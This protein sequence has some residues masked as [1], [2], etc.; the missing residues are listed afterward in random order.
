MKA[1]LVDLVLLGACEAVVRTLAP[2]LPVPERYQVVLHVFVVGLL[3]LGVAALRSPTPRRVLWGLSHLHPWRELLIGIAFTVVLYLVATAALAPLA[4]LSAKHVEAAAES[5]KAA[6]QTL[7]QVPMAPAILV[8]IF[9]GV[10]EE[11]VFRG[12]LLSR[13]QSALLR[14]GSAVA[15]RIAIVASAIVFA[16][17]HAY[18]GPVGMVQSLVV[19]VLLGFLRLRRGT[20]FAPIGSHVFIDVLGFALLPLLGAQRS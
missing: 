9:A 20:L 19:G 13:I 3:M 16:L 15:G 4:L 8:A 12:F 10:Y 1:L 6:L 2:H 17:G 11:I 18:Q 5:K 7:A 14:V